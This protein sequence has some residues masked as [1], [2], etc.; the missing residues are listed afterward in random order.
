MRILY[1]TDSFWP[2]I[3]GIEVFSMRLLTA[4]RSCG[5]ELRVVTPHGDLDLPDMETYRDIPIHRFHFLDAL[6]RRSLSRIMGIRRRVAGLKRAFAPD[7]IHVVMPTVTPTA[8]FHLETAGACAAP[9][10][11]TL[12]GAVRATAV[13]PQTL[14]GRMLRDADWVT[15]VSSVTLAEARRL[16][17]EVSA[18][19]SVIHNNLDVPSVPP[20]PL[21][22]ETPRVLCVGRL[23]SEK[24]FDV[25]LAAFALVSE[26]V[27]AARFMVAGDGP[28]R[29]LLERRAADLG[30]GARVQF[31][32]WV[33]PERV[34][35]LMN[36]ASV[37]VVPSR[38]EAFGITALE[39]GS[40][41]RPV[42][43]TRAGGLPEVVM[44]GETGLLVEAEDADAMGAAVAWLLEH[45]DT[46]ARMGDAA[47]RR[48][49]SEF[50]LERAVDAYVELYRR[51]AKEGLHHASTAG[52]LP[53]E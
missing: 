10:L 34:P 4:L 29:R 38:E 52:S 8:L 11:V 23:T 20:M 27:P 21:P 42:V 53:S 25:A 39:A 22:C 1:W 49:A 12:Q 31:L 43:A 6:A 47:R 7:V 14:P 9:T 48:V 37:V 15:A 44:H 32:G 30:L 26:R 28:E 5:H 13:D 51:L 2:Y 50:R 33:A 16:A 17:P 46:A 24:G 36:T 45:P 19:S 41:A 40:M 18:R 3:G 35:E